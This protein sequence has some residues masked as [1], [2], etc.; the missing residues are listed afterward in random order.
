M[1]QIE[2]ELEIAKL[3]IEI[4]TLKLQI[5]ELESKPVECVP[6]PVYP[7]YPP[8]WQYTRTGDYLEPPGSSYNT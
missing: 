7:S 4:L 1:T 6:Y 8:Y 5:K 2:Y 3:K